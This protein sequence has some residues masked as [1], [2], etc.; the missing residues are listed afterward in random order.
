MRNTKISKARMA[1]VT[2]FLDYIEKLP[3]RFW[4][5]DSPEL[6][7]YIE[8]LTEG[9]LVKAN[10]ADTLGGVRKYILPYSREVFAQLVSKY[11]LWKYIYVDHKPH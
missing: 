10:R 8:V 1:Q 6:Q 7:C 3:N 4:I 9:G 5:W 11:G 2:E